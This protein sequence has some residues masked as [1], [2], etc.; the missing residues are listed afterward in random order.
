MKMTK[1]LAALATCAVMTAT[2]MV[3]I[4]ASAV[5][6]YDNYDNQIT[7]NDLTTMLSDNGFKSC[8]N[9]LLK[10]SSTF[11]IDENIF[12]AVVGVPF[13]V[14]FVDSS[15]NIITDYS[16]VIYPIICDDNIVAM[17][18]ASKNEGNFY[19]SVSA[20][21]SDELNMA[22]SNANEIALICDD[23]GNIYS[24]EN[25]GTTDVVYFEDESSIQSYSFEFN[26]VDDFN[27]VVSTEYLSTETTNLT[28]WYNGS[29]AVTTRK[30]SNYPCVKQSGANCWAYAILSIGRYKLGSWLP[31]EQV[32]TGFSISNGETYVLDSGA[33]L[34]ESYNT[35]VWLFNNY[36]NGYSPVKTTDKI[37][38]NQIVK[39]IQQDLP[40]YIKGTR[41]AADG[42]TVGHAVALM[43][44]ERDGSTL[45][46][47]YVMNPQQG[48][49]EYNPYSHPNC[50]F[51]N[52]SKTAKYLWNGTITLNGTLS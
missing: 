30:I 6:D 13:H 17:I 41:T 52:S 1:K 50:Y 43:G 38:A 19:F 26:N 14:P 23:F 9:V 7:E 12:E 3:G 24:V 34:T 31:I 8:A 4:S 46:G 33:T 47:I 37:S 29:R 36:S 51:S 20:G 40:I 16:S 11:G 35:M 42:S 15:A 32:Y 48:Q 39:N 25:D 18:S 2:S 21:F 45:T 22:L 44:Y 27:N 49:I 28:S 10:D 5:D